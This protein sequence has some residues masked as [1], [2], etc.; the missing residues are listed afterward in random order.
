ML[1]MVQRNDEKHEEGHARLRGDLRSLESRIVSLETARAETGAQ[2]RVLESTVKRMA[3]D[4]T[5]VTR[6]KFSPSIVVS[7]LVACLTVA[8]GMWGSTYG[9]RSDVRDILTQ[10]AANKSLDASNAKLIEERAAALNR[11]IDMIEKKQELQRL[12]LQSLKETIL[13]QRNK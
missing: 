11:T 3:T 6:L 2:M 13:Q 7:I 12:E 1:E 8:G 4:P 10:M 9:L 5:D